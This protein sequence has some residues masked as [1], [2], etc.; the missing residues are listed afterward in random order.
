MTDL[1]LAEKYF[2]DKYWPVLQSDYDYYLFT[3]SPTDNKINTDLYDYSDSRLF[4]NGYYVCLF[5]D[6]SNVS[7][8]KDYTQRITISHCESIYVIN[9]QKRYNLESTGDYVIT[10]FSVS[11]NNYLD[12]FS[13]T[14]Y[15]K[16]NYFEQQN[17]N[18]GSDT[19]PL[20]LSGFVPYFLVL[21]TLLCLIFFSLVFRRR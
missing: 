8:D 14:A 19:Q 20:D 11:I 18:S 3:M 6:T 17:S 5:N 15:Y 13:T 12:N 9:V 7:V 21:S 2:F 10:Q 1:E 16:T 4:V